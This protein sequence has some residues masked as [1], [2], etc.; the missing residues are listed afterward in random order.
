MP[1]AFKPCVGSKICSS[2]DQNCHPYMAWSYISHTVAT[3]HEW[4]IIYVCRCQCNVSAKFIQILMWERDWEINVPVKLDEV[5]KKEAA[6]PDCPDRHD[7]HPTYKE[8]TS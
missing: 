6:A 4:F 3:Q 8:E 2:N 5:E 1:V 7:L